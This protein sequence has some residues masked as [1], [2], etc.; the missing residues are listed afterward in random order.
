M[1]G[2]IHST[3]PHLLLVAQHVSH[4]DILFF[5]D[6]AGK[7]DWSGLVTKDIVD[8]PMQS[9]D[10]YVFTNVNTVVNSYAVLATRMLAEMG[11]GGEAAKSARIQSAMDTFLYNRTN[12]RYCDGNC[13][14]ANASHTSLHASIFPLAFDLVPAERVGQTVEWVRTRGM[15]CSI[16]GAFP[17]LEA[18]FGVG[19]VERNASY[20]AGLGARQQSKQRDWEQREQ[21]E[22]E[23]E[24]QQQRNP[25]QQQ[26]QQQQQQLN[27]HQHRQDVQAHPEEVGSSSALDRNPATYLD[28]GAAAVALITSC[29][30]GEGSDV[31]FG[32]W[33]GMIKQNATCTMVRPP[34]PSFTLIQTI[35]QQGMLLLV[36]KDGTSHVND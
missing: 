14:D 25:Q 26:Q 5:C 11:V 24:Q 10:G 16:Y 15:A 18:L 23:R 12:G 35:Q 13:A 28:Y 33:C 1:C 27:H 17:L 34:S 22:Q 32:S 3:P 30:T 31:G 19:A 4:L 2:S 6:V 8:W 20:A 7:Q 29:D 21:L 36:F 9:R